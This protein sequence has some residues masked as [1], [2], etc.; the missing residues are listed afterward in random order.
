M[1]T[2]RKTDDNKNDDN[3]DDSCEKGARPRRT[4]GGQQQLSLDDDD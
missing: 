4:D 3:A 2:S 1:M